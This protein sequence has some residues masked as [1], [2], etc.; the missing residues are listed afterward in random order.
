MADD[1]GNGWRGRTE[2]RLDEIERRMAAVESH[3]FQCPQLR[4]VAD[5]EERL[6]R[7]ESMRWQIAGVV[8]VVQ[9]LGVGII[10][11]AVKGWIK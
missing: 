11:S 2:A 1:T 6:R 9:A 5:H 7:L 8:A 3:P 10:L 4:V